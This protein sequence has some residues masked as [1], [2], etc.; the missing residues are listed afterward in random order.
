MGRPPRGNAACS[1]TKRILMTEEEDAQYTALARYQGMSFSDLVRF[2]LRS[3]LR[4]LTR[5]GEKVPKK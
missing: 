4:R 3:E 2:L 1:T 5:N